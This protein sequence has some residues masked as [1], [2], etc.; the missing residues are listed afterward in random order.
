MEWFAHFEKMITRLGSTD[1]PV[2][3]GPFGPTGRLLHVF[4][5]IDARI[6]YILIFDFFMFRLAREARA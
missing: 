5:K 4:S 1:V 2:V 6:Y 3:L